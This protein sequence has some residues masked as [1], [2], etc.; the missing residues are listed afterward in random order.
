[1]TR[2]ARIM[3]GIILITFPTIQ[4]GGYFLL[5]SLMTKGSGYIDNP[6]QPE[7]FPC[8]ACPRGRHCD[9]VPD[10]PSADR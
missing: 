10:L 7:F 5:T 8:R 6:L 4:Y 9:S 1:M 2:E 3:S